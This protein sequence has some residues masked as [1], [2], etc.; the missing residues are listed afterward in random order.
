MV[1][2]RGALVVDGPPRA[3]TAWLLLE[4]PNRNQFAAGLLGDLYVLDLASQR[5]ALISPDSVRGSPPS[6][7]RGLGLAVAGGRLYIYGGGKES[8]GGKS[9]VHVRASPS[10]HALVCARVCFCA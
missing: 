2:N 8:N 5:W 9:P 10:F 1:S 3:A 6:P 7:R 4:E